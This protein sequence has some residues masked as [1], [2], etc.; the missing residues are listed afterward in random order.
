MAYSSQ[1][2]KF[3]HQN[4]WASKHVIVVNIQMRYTFV[5]CGLPCRNVLSKGT[6]RWR[7]ET[8]LG[9]RMRNANASDKHLYKKLS[10]N[11]SQFE[12]P[13]EMVARDSNFNLVEKRV[14]H[15]QPL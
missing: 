15:L 14:E 3:L 13:F 4:W 1:H 5:V 12:T 11:V 8:Y 7:S 9:A 6:I 2:G 10:G